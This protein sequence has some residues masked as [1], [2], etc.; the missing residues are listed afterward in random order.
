M[1][2]HM[3]TTLIIPD[4]VFR[5][6][7]RTADKRGTTIS[8]LTAELLRKG[9]AERPKLHHLPP[10]P[11]FKTGGLSVDVADREALY[12]ALNAEDDARL[13]GRR[14]KKD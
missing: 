12:E 13:Y 11:S 14:L 5:D 6:L 1:V 9:L 10:L 3:K 4:A 2:F 7:K 8:E